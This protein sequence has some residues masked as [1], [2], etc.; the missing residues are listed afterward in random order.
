MTHQ[1]PVPLADLLNRARQALA[2]PD[3]ALPPAPPATDEAGCVVFLA[4]GEGE[5]RARVVMGRG[6]DTEAA[7][8]AA[9]EALAVKAK[10]AERP[11]QRLRAEIVERTTPMTW[12]N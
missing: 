5:S 6:P 1:A 9:A 7:W 11:A 12:A 3:G 4:M 2:T 8:Q 10:R